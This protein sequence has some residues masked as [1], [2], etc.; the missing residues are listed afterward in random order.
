[1]LGRFMQQK[2]VVGL[3]NMRNSLYHDVC[4]SITLD[5]ASMVKLFQVC[6]IRGPRSGIL[7][8]EYAFDKE[9]V[10]LQSQVFSLFWER[11]YYTCNI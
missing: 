11:W 1:M 6:T 3:L 8:A 10:V 4:E 7:M 5:W 9:S 2:L